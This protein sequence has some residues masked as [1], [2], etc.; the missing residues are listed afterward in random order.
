M[1][2][3]ESMRDRGSPRIRA[4]IG[5]GLVAC[6]MV[7]LP[8]SGGAQPLEP[9]PPPS[10]SPMACPPQTVAASSDPLLR[11]L[12]TEWS[13]LKQDWC[14]VLRWD[15]TWPRVPGLLV[16]VL[17]ARGVHATACFVVSR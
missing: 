5:G 2:S 10:E 9:A 15:D 3:G 17:I 4:W 8:Q 12:I 7:C 13:R 11:S 16:V 6:A 1:P 14:K